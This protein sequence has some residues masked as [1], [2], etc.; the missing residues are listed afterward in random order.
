MEGYY[1]QLNSRIRQLM[2]EGKALID[3]D[4]LTSCIDLSNE[5]REDLERICRN[6]MASVMLYQ[7]NF[8]SF[9]RGRGLYINYEMAKNPAIL[10]QLCENASQSTHKKMIIQQLLELAEKNALM[11]NGGQMQMMVDDNGEIIVFEELSKQE[12]WDLLN[13]KLG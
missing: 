6:A 12:L 3:K 9:V 7:N 8:R 10:S 11:E 4:E 13:E 2:A 5:G 1:S